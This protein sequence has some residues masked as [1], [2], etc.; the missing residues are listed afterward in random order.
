VVDQN[1]DARRFWERLGFDL[2]EK[3]SGIRYG[4]RDTT[5]WVMK[6]AVG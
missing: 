1:P 2:L 6:R 4:S 5:L 3:R